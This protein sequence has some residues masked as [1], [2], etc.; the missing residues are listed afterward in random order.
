MARPCAGRAGTPRGT[1]TAT[2]PTT[3]RP[4]RAPLGGL[5]HDDGEGVHVED[6]LPHVGDLGGAHLAIFATGD[7][8]AFFT[9]APALL[10][11]GPLRVIARR[12][13]QQL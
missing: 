11:R 7:G 1:G 13:P 10:G 12:D 9:P 2:R 8:V 4:W 3:R 6:G 5:R